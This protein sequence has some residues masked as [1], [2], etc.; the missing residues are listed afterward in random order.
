MKLY[1]KSES[2]KP[3]INGSE[4]VIFWTPKLAISV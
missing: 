4:I 3:K 1:K 2:L